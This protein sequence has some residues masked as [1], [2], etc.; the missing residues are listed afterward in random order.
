MPRCPSRFFRCST[1]PATDRSA[2]CTG[3]SAPSGSRGRIP[4]PATR[5]P[6]GYAGASRRSRPARP[7]PRRPMSPRSVAEATAIRSGPGPV[8]LLTAVE[9]ETRTL[10]RRLGR[11]AGDGRLA[12]RTAGLGAS[13][14]AR[15]G[16]EWAGA[17]PTAVLSVGLAGGCAPDVRPGELIVGTAVG[18]RPDGAWLAADPALAEQAQAALATARLPHRF[19]RLLTASAVVATPVAKA[20]IWARHGAVAV[21]MES[22]HV[23]AWAAA[24]GVPALAVRAVADGPDEP[25]PPA[26]LGALGPDGAVRPMALVGWLG[27][28]RLLAAAWCAWRRSSAALH[29]LARFLAAFAA[30]RP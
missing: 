24:A 8:L 29:Q 26:L 10:A 5:M 16:A 4:R 18:P 17:G 21:D 15:S 3:R 22:A 13:R 1:G 23:L 2:S 11:Q 7:C 6:P 27:R 9:F 25:L 30:V 28:P 20:G 12:L 19:G 14:L